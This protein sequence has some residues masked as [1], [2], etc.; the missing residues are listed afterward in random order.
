VGRDG[1]T[2]YAIPL[3]RLREIMKKYP[4]PPAR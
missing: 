1:N 4:R 2:A 3:D